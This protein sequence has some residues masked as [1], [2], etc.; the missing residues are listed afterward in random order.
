MEDL[1]EHLT[2]RCVEVDTRGCDFPAD[3][4]SL[5]DEELAILLQQNKTEAFDE[6]MRRYKDPVLNFVFRFVG[7]M[8][9]AE[10]VVQETFVRVYQKR[11]LYRPSARFSTWMYT[12]A[13]NLAKSELRRPFRR[14]GRSLFKDDANDEYITIVD[15]EPLP[16]RV[17]DSSFK[18]RRIQEALLRLPMK[19]REVVILF[20]MQGLHYDEISTI[21]ELPEGTVKSRLFRGRA[22]LKEL[23]KDIYD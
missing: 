11:D 21:I 14:L 19:F 7:S 15:Q 6:L 20:D 23:L 22:I 12:I 17:A 9:L 10:D 16:D 13:S 2:E 18:Y 5:S 8:E 3:L 1:R 4:V